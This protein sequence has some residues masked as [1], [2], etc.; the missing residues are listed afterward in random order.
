MKQWKSQYHTFSVV[1]HE[2]SC[3]KLWF[4]MH[5]LS[6][7]LFFLL[8]IKREFQDTVWKF[9]NLSTIHIL[10]EINFSELNLSNL[11]NWGNFGF[12]KIKIQSL[13]NCQKLTL[14]I[15]WNISVAEKWSN[16]HTVQLK[17]ARHQAPCFYVPQPL[18]F[19]TIFIFF[20]FSL[21]MNMSFERGF[22][23]L[24]FLLR[25]DF[26]PKLLASDWHRNT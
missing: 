3:F 5:K 22:I 20:H 4:S 23:K 25:R 7:K 17:W 10:R 19:S 16:F 14:L 9:K 18:C 21:W 15:S 11:F 24:N 26:A 13:K 1:C 8:K 6:I 12:S 2:I